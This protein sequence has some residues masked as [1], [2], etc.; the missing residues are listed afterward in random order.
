MGEWNAYLDRDPYDGRLKIDDEGNCT[1]TVKEMEPV[2]ALIS[3]LLGEWAYNLRAALDYCAYAVAICD[4][5]QDPPPGAD[6]IQ[7]PIYADKASYERNE[8]R[9][10]PLSEKHRTWAESIQPY[11]GTFGPK[12]TGLYWVNELARIDRHRK[13]H[14][15]GMT[16]AETA[17]MVW[18]K[19][20]THDVAL[21]F[22]DSP[23]GQFV[24]G[25]AVVARFKIVPYSPDYKI[26][27]NPNTHFDVEIGEMA[28][29]RPAEATYL[30]MPLSQR[31]LLISTMVGG[32]IG[33][34]E[35]DCLGYT[36]AKFLRDE[37]EIEGPAK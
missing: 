30:F 35:R 21:L 11:H 12:G 22:E 13:L 19:N 7:F 20:A 26:E 25:E 36:R 1:L 15:V 23:V 2:R 4:S 28:S 29:E 31:L 6:L 3:V 9:I 32:Y 18:V 27:A 24:E 33:R 37:A 34:F 16:Q 10:K 8:Y 14:V 5:K 17:P